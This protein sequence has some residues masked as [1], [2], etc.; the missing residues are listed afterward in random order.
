MLEKKPT[1][2]EEADRI[3]VEWLR[4]TLTA[5]HKPQ[6]EMIGK[7]GRPSKRKRKAIDSPED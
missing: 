6:K 7:V 5:P 1:D 4:H 2:N 3:A